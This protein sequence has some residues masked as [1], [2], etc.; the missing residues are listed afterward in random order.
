MNFKYLL[1]QKKLEMD[2]LKARWIVMQEAQEI[3]AK[4]R[5]FYEEQ[6]EVLINEISSLEGLVRSVG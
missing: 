1:A 6:L 2:K 5:M 4:V 3:T